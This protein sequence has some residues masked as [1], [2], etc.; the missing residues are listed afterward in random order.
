MMVRTP[1][2]YHSTCTQP[3]KGSTHE[4]I[5]GGW[6]RI[7][8]FEWAVKGRCIEEKWLKLENILF[9]NSFWKKLEGFAKVWFPNS[10]TGR[11][12]SDFQVYLEA[13]WDLPTFWERFSSGHKSHIVVAL[14]RTFRSG[15]FRVERHICFFEKVHPHQLIQWIVPSDT[16]VHVLT[17]LGYW[18]HPTDPPGATKEFD[19]CTPRSLAFASKRSLH[20]G[21]TNPPGNSSHLGT[22]KN[23]WLKKCVWDMLLPGRVC[24]NHFGAP[25]CEIFSETLEKD[26]IYRRP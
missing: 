9:L 22:R 20:G 2:N 5:F 26:I 17:F 1:W 16:I 24:L 21:L 15:A 6:H 14:Q 23:H 3:G 11:L 18:K 13:F 4:G 12:I 7:L 19:I 8:G 10:R 25:R